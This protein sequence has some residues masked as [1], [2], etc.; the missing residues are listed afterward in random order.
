MCIGKVF[1]WEYGIIGSGYLILFGGN[2]LIDKEVK[3]DEKVCIR[4]KR[5]V[6]IL[7]SE[8]D[9]LIFGSNES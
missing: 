7:C 9:I 1:L 6:G 5:L 2:M 4:F 8:R 3:I